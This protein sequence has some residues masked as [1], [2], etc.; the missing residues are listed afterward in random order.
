MSVRIPLTRERVV[1]AAAAVADARGLAG[2]S[3]RNVGRQLGVEAMSLYHHVA[4]KEQ[5]LDELADWV[6]TRIHLAAPGADWRTEMRTRA[7]SA[8]HV[9]GEH[10]WGLALVESRRTPGPA[11]LAHHDAVLGCLRAAGF[12]VRQAAHAFSVLDAYVY[13]FVLTE[14][15]LPFTPDER[16]EDFTDALALP[17]EQYPHLVELVA[18]VVVGRDYAYADEFEHGLEL[19]LDGIA[20]RLAA[21]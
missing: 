13:G 16:V 18:E 9:L 7:C 17:A 4:G 6:F 11:S 3:M 15:R 1:D 14:Q 5:L 20:A 10:P 8:R 21:P 12:D 2:V 19:V